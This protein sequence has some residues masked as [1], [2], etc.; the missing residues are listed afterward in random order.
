ML[1]LVGLAISVVVCVIA[2]VKHKMS[3]KLTEGSYNNIMWLINI[4]IM[5]NIIII[6]WL[7]HCVD[8]D[9]QRQGS[10]ESNVIVLQPCGAYDVIQL[11]KQRITL[12]KNAAYGKI[13]VI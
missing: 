11:S 13:G 10:T 6:S 2:K 5:N 8:L 1:S 3:Q 9:T 12:D 7:S 4:V